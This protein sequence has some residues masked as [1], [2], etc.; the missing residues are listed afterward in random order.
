MGKKIKK[1]NERFIE[2]ILHVGKNQT[3]NTIR[4]RDTDTDRQRQRDR[5]R[6]RERERE[7]RRGTYKKQIQYNNTRTISITIQA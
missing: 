2:R 6:Q 3:P 5:E 4:K 7:I 1:L